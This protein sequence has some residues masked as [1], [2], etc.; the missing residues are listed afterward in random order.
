[1]EIKNCFAAYTHTIIDLAFGEDEFT[2]SDSPAAQEVANTLYHR[3]RR[4]KKTSFYK[5]SCRLG[6]IT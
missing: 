2:Y 4:F 1:M 5:V 6:L 3:I